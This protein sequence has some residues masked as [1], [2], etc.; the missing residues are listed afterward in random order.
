MAAPN[1][2]IEVADYLPYVTFAPESV[3]SVTVE[4]TYDDGTVDSADYDRNAVLIP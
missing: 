2:M 3:Q 4:I 1:V